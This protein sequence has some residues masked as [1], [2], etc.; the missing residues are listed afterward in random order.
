MT[1]SA[2]HQPTIQ[3]LKVG[4]TL[5]SRRPKSVAPEIIDGLINLYAATAYVG[6]KLIP[7]DAGINPM[8]AVATPDGPRR[9][10]ILIA[11]SPHKSGSALTPWED[12][13]APDDGYVRYFGDAKTPGATA[14]A[15][16]GNALLTAEFERHHGAKSRAE[17][18][19]ATPLVFFR[20]QPYAGKQ[21]GYPRFQGF[22][23]ITAVRLIT[24]HS[25]AVGGAFSNLQFECAV[26][27]MAA[28]GEV[29]D[30]SWINARRNDHLSDEAALKSAPASWQSW[31]EHGVSEVPRL[32]RRVL[33]RSLT[34]TAEQ[35]PGPGRE[36]ALL[37]AIYEHYEGK[38]VYF[39][40][41]AAEIAARIIA[42]TG[43]GYTQHGVT[44]GSGDFGIDFIAQLD[45]GEG[46]TRTPLVVLGQAKCVAPG[47]GTNAKDLARTVARL[48]RGWLGVFV[49]TGVITERAQRE[50]YEDR[51]PLVMIPGRTVAATVQ[52][53]LAESGHTNTRKLLES[54]DLQHE[55]SPRVAD[56]E[57]LIV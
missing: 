12:V 16:P 34:P 35:T 5:R 1:K 18:L 37:Q 10:A 17:R 50:V 3:Q 15:A 23:F 47:T 55:L 45:I 4:Q 24:Q 41:L 20:R 14:S 22:G 38:K 40:S 56:P 32:R 13:F 19:R 6:S 28:E 27:S 44:R 46:F 7:F 2:T 43:T 54:Y 36:G 31:V 26:L 9:P 52:Q 33:R 51:Y 29:F 25:D 57:Q 39:E 21:K 11:S 42:P 30:W 49:T 53:L 8:A 48:R